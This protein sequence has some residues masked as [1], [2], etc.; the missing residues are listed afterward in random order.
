MEWENRVSSESNS[1]LA[2]YFKHRSFLLT[3]EDADVRVAQ[4]GAVDLFVSASRV[5]V[6]KGLIDLQGP[7]SFIMHPVGGDTPLLAQR[8]QADGPI[9]AAWQTLLREI[10]G[11]DYTFSPLSTCHF[12]VILTRSLTWVPSRFSSSD[13]TL[14]VCPFSFISLAH[15]RGSHTL[16]T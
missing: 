13:L 6:C 8:P 15:V 3:D 9:W 7:D 10:T 4:V 14:S 12:W 5:N 11:S 16:R 1:V 2:S